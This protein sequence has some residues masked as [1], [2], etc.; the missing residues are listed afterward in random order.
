MESQLD[1]NPTAPVTNNKFQSIIINIKINIKRVV[2]IKV[3]ETKFI[4]IELT[5]KEIIIEY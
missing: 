4:T 2:E 5:F 1:V 3:I